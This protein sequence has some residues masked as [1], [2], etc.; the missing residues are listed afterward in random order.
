LTR[1]SL[2]GDGCEPGFD[3]R[4]A[5]LHGGILFQLDYLDG[6]VYCLAGPKPPPFAKVALMVCAHQDCLR[7]RCPPRSTAD[8]LENII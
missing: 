6:Q 1:I 7:R 3:I 8:V 4:Y 5:D 2:P